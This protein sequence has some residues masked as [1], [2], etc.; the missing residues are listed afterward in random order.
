MGA[1]GNSFCL[2]FEG[3]NEEAVEGNFTNNIP[4]NGEINKKNRK[5]IQQ[6]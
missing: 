2:S 6:R 1:V 3:T 5:L 4:T